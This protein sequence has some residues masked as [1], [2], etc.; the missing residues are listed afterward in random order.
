MPWIY[1][2]PNEYVVFCFV[3]SVKK[4]LSR[5]VLISFHLLQWFSQSYSQTFW[6]M[7]LYLQI[8]FIMDLNLML[9][10]FSTQPTKKNKTNPKINNTKSVKK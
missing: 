9:H 8:F 6:A 5:I 3:F 4:N 10:Q 1:E 2:K 7:D